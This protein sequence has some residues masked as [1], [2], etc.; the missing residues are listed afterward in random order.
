M[1]NW[2]MN[3]LPSVEQVN[4]E[5]YYEVIRK[6]DPELYMIKVALKETNINPL[7]VT[8]FIRALGIMAMG[9]G[10]GVVRVYMEKR[11]ISQIKGEESDLLN[12]PAKT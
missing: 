8:R 6:C 9:T 11:K 3:S 7:V 5:K 4:L 12:V 10:Y 1:E 2:K